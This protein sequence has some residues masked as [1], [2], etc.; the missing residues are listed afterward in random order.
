MIILLQHQYV[1]CPLHDDHLGL[2]SFGQVI[3]TLLQ[4]IQVQQRILAATGGMGDVL[5]GLIGGLMA[6]GLEPAL[7]TAT[8]VGAHAAAGD[9]AWDSAGVGLTASDVIANLGAVLTASYSGSS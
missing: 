3:K 4:Q 2:F 1:A 5:A 8:A 9:V 6:Q 7:A